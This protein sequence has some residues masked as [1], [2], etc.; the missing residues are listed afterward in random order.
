M[1]Y[2]S[3]TAWSSWPARCNTGLALG[4][5]HGRR[6]Y[7]PSILTLAPRIVSRSD[8]TR[9][10]GSCTSP[11]Y[12]GMEPHDGPGHQCKWNRPPRQTI[13]RCSHQPHYP[14]WKRIS[15]NALDLDAS[16]QEQTHAHLSEWDTNGPYISL[17][18]L[19]ANGNSAAHVSASHNDCERRRTSLLP[20][21]TTHFSRNG[22]MF[23]SADGNPAD[24]V[25]T[26]LLSLTLTLHQ[27][28]PSVRLDES[29]RRDVGK[30]AGHPNEGSH[31]ALPDRLFQIDVT[32]IEIQVHGA[33]SLEQHGERSS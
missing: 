16:Q 11:I 1:E 33:M 18:W 15:Y 6:T 20:P 4:R 21:L 28:Q 5:H 2:Y 10:L 25:S 8:L 9:T 24:V 31:H 7:R 14:F 12:M 3:E 19:T 23:G 13:R 32:S 30:R 29:G 17:S 26:S 22:Q 27:H